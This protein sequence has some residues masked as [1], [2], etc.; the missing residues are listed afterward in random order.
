MARV[1]FDTRQTSP[2]KVLV[3]GVIWTLIAALGLFAF[4]SVNAFGGGDAEKVTAVVIDDG[5]YRDRGGSTM[6]QPV[7][8][9]EYD[10]ATHEIVQGY[11]SSS[12]R[13]VGAKVDVEIRDGDP[14]TASI[15]MTGAV[16]FVLLIF[17]LIGVVLIASGIV[18]LVRKKRSADSG[19][20]DHGG[21]PGSVAETE[22][23]RGAVWGNAAAERAGASSPGAQQQVPQQQGWV[24]QPQQVP[25]QV[26]QQGWSPQQ[27][28]QPRQPQGW[29]PQ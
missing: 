8:S 18:G 25:Q 17:P 20:D 24:G 26:P 27:P 4:A 22:P 5:R 16:K 9:F 28:Q 23:W 2:A 3:G 10:G 29:S 14:S 13:A 19:N 15:P 12:C 11:S 6:C 1:R 21:W 7:V